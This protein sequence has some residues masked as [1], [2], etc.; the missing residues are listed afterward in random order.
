[1]NANDVLTLG[2][3]VTPPWKLVGQRLDMTC[4]GLYL[5][6]QSSDLGVRLRASDRSAQQATAT[7]WLC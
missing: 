7:D 2:L 6:G 4:I 1:M 3:G 5:I